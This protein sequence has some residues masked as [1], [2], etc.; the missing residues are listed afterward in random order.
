ME[1]LGGPPDI[2]VNNVGL[3]P[4]KP[5]ENLEDDDWQRSFELNLMSAVRACRALLPPMSRRGSGAVVSIASDLAKQPE[6]VP[7]DYGAFKAA[8]VS[9][10]KSLAI[11]YA[12]SGVR[13]NA[14]C[15]G[16]IWTGLWSRPGGVVDDLAALY[17]L[18]PEQALRRFQDER[19]LMLGMGQP[20]DVARLVAF[21]VSPAARH[22]TASAHDVNGGSVRS[23]L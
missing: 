19:R 2:L 1:R 12:E 5:V 15:P 14:V 11:R 22:I 18:P 23:L 7:A 16:P 4:N 9:L 21:L 6:A 17:G 8:L 20:E 10:S 13:V 3:A